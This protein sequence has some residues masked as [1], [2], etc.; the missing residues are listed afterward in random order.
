[1]PSET[2][3]EDMRLSA[4]QRGQSARVIAIHASDPALVDRL[5]LYGLVSGAQITLEQ[6][7][8]MFVLQIGFTEL[9]IEGEIANDIQ[10][11]VVNVE[12]VLPSTRIIDNDF[13]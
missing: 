8:P 5:H 1:M 13:P 7:S 3:P 10:V 9:S 2:T 6:R 12:N 11:K 4:L